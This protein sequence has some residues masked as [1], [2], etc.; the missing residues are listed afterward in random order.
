MSEGGGSPIKRS[1]PYPRA[2]QRKEFERLEARVAAMENVF[3]DIADMKD[4]VLKI[5]K[6]IKI[7]I[8]SIVSAAL[9]AGLVDGRMGKFLVA[10]FGSG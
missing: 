7:A 1:G 2:V 3:S 5:A 10:L 6:Y 9:A 8:P 4:G